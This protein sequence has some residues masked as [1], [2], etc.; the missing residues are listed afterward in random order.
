MNDN[1][2]KT[3]I[4]SIVALDLIDYAKKTSAEKLEVKRLFNGFIQNAM[5]DIPESDRN[6][7]DTADGAAIACKG[8]LEDALEDALFVSITIR[9][10]ILKHN[11]QSATPLYVQFG[12]HLGA[13]RALNDHIVGEGVD[14]AQRIMRFANANQILVS[15]VYFEMASKLTQEIAQM[16]EKYEMHAYEHD[17]YAVR[18]LKEGMADDAAASNADGTVAASSIASSLNW[19]YVGLGLLSLAAFLMLAKL[20]MNPV[21]P[22]ITLV[23]PEQIQPTPAPAAIK[24]AEPVAEVN[25]QEPPLPAVEETIVETKV[26]TKVENEPVAAASKPKKENVKKL[27]P[28]PTLKAD[29]EKSTAESNKAKP[30]KTAEEKAPTT[31]SGKPS[32]TKSAETKPEKETTKQAA[33]EVQ[34]EKSGW[35]TFKDSV[36][37]GADRKCTQAEI[38]LNQCSK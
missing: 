25:N 24:P 38:A 11:L 36:I 6:I 12:I 27:I 16:F 13:A 34:K 1:A 22:T 23:Q 32:E 3:S 28:K 2:N 10:E 19:T 18:L 35:Q 20:V 9:D 8:A 17:V 4:C 30:A 21:E 37:T 14:E 26:E 31:K 7:I 29:V 15:N 33:K 5:L